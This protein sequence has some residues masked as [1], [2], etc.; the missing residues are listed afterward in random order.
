M[1][2]DPL[3]LI[4]SAE[5]TGIFED[6]ICGVC[7]CATKV[8]LDKADLSADGVGFECTNGHSDHIG[9]DLIR[10]ALKDYENP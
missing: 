5:K 7:M 6:S 8:D 9:M 3:E 10:E 4:Q 2:K 1:P